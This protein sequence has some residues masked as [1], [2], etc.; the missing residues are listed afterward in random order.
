MLDAFHD[1]LDAIYYEGY[2]HE[3]LHTNPDGYRYELEQF[4][5]VYTMPAD[6]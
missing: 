1:Y 3:L 4:L 6:V 2:A 5:R